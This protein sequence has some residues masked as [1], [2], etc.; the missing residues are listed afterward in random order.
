MIKKLGDQSLS[1]NKENQSSSC[2]GSVDSEFAEL[3][4]GKEEPG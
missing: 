4:G 2:S 3:A 1:V